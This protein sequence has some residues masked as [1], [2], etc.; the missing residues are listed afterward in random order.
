HERARPPLRALV[1]RSGDELLPG[2]GLA[3]D[4]YRRVGRRYLLHARDHRAHRCRVAHD[5]FEHRRLVH[6]L[7]E[8][9]VLVMHP[10]LGALAIVDVGACREPANHAALGIVHGHIAREDPPI[11]SVW[12]SQA[13]L[14]LASDPFPEPANVRSQAWPVLRM[15]DFAPPV[16]T[17]PALFHP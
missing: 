13:H 3:G 5:L 8:R 12:S 16:T 4:E 2:A 1:D 17:S 6:L 9:D 11:L 7:A 14:E 10:L 15:D